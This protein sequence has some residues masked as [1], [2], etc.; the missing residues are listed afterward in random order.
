MSGVWRHVTKF[1]TLSVRSRKVSKPRDLYLELSYSSEIW[2]ALRQHF[3]AMRQF[4][5]PI[6]WLLD[7]TRS[8]E[9]TY[10]RILRRGPG[11]QPCLDCYTVQ[12]CW[13]KD[14]QWVMRHG[15]QLVG[16]TLL[17]LVCLN[18]GWDCL[19]S[20]CILSSS[21]DW[22]EFP[23]FFKAHWQSPC[24]PLTAG[25]RL[26]L[27]LCKEIMKESKPCQSPPLQT[28]HQYPTDTS[29]LCQNDIT[30]SFWHTSV[31]IA[32]CVHWVRSSGTHFY[33]FLMIM[34][35]NWPVNLWPCPHFHL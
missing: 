31:I 1:Y 2:Q 21:H 19:V 20:Q 24:T 22:W 9:K 33:T 32:S 13:Y 26:Q 30:T 27:G 18:I 4:K 12:T 5:I 15:L 29:L 6:S 17:W 3:K 35:V 14:C 28:H 7:F 10:F 34:R 23:P 25:K 16:I 11:I 8:Y